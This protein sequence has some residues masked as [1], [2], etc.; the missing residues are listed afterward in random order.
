[1]TMAKTS[2]Y[3]TSQPGNLVTALPVPGGVASMSYAPDG[4]SLLIV[5]ALGGNVLIWNGTTL[6]TVRFSS[7]LGPV[8][9][10]AF[11]PADLPFMPTGKEIA[12]ATA[13]GKL[14]LEDLDTGLDGKPGATI[15]A[16]CPARH[17]AVSK[18]GMHIAFSCP[19]DKLGVLDGRTKSFRVDTATST[20]EAM[21]FSPDGDTLIIGTADGLVWRRDESNDTT[22][23]VG[24]H[25]GAVTAVAFSPDGQWFASAGA[26]GTV[27]IYPAESTRIS[28]RITAYSDPVSALAF[29]VDSGHLVAFGGS[30]SAAQIWHIFPAPVAELCNRIPYNLSVSDW[31]KWVSSS[32]G[33]RI[34]CGDKPQQPAD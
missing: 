22:T 3:G 29:T 24:V 16:G 32:I 1:M 11:M 20:V 19:G 28:A 33:Y 26:D 27:L 8:T 15:D 23:S 9:A 31:N 14:L 18:D 21:A 4:G 12:I 10:A 34:Q 6:S 13:S 17:I 7:D 30:E 2:E 5:T 25:R